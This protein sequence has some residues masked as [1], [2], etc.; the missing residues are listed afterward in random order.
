[1]FLCYYYYYF[2]IVIAIITVHFGVT[3]YSTTVAFPCR[4]AIYY[5]L[6]IIIQLINSLFLTENIQ[7]EFVSMYM[8]ST[9][10][11]L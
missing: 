9:K 10:L 1:M 7:A 6:F 11:T 5:I 2:I 3:L 4:L 8:Y